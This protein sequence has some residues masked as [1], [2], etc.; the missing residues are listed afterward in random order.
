MNS[1]ETLPVPRSFLSYQYFFF[2]VLYWGFRAVQM[3]DL[4]LLTGA[5]IKYTGLL[6]MLCLLLARAVSPAEKTRYEPLLQDGVR[7]FSVSLL[8]FLL[9]DLLFTSTVLW[10]YPEVG[11]KDVM[12]FAVVTY[13]GWAL[14]ALAS[15]VTLRRWR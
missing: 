5:F 3:A 10:V 14:F 11:V 15:L 6:L 9:S 12:W 2:L 13:G 4:A 1:A 8:F 7:S